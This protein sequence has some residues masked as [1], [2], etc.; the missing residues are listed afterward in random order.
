MFIVYMYDL[1]A[2]NKKLFN[3]NK[4]KF[5]YHLNKISIPTDSWKTKSTLVINQ[6]NLEKTLDIFFKKF[7]SFCTCYK[8]ETSSISLI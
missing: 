4:R 2:K 7:S 8:F 3:R 5:Y 1:T 6:T